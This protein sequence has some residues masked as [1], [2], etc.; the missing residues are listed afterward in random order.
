MEINKNIS[1]EGF[2]LVDKS[3]GKTS[4]DEVYVAKKK[5]HQKRIGHVG[6][7]DPF[8]NGLLILALSRYTKLFFLFD[9]FEKEYIA[10]GVFGES[11]DTDD[12]TGS[13]IQKYEDDSIPNQ[14]DI[15]NL[16]IEKFSGNIK[17][18]PPIFSAKKVNGRRAYKIARSGDIP[19]LK[20]ADVFIKNIELLDYSYPYFTIKMSVSKGT[21]IRSIIRDIGSYFN[22]GAYTDKLTRTAIGDITLEDASKYD[23]RI[24]GIR[25]LF[26]NIKYTQIENDKHKSMILNG[27]KDF[28]K[29]LDDEDIKSEESK[30]LFLF[31]EDDRFLAV[32]DNIEMTYAYVS[33]MPNL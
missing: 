2:V 28:L 31:D 16:L 8:A 24:L 27:N 11:R 30:Y 3:V 23:G 29:Y 9:D 19:I 12:I 1:N 7:L 20:E 21:Y 18:M 17:Q 10:R 14:N 33:V 5:Y 4:F 25:D 13:I 6:T 15:E 26:K 22:I 32:V